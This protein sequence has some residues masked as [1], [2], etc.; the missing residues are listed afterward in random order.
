VT[1][2]WRW[3]VLGCLVLVPLAAAS[4]AAPNALLTLAIKCSATVM[5]YVAIRRYRPA[6]A[7]AW[8]LLWTA[9]LFVCLGDS[10][11]TGRLAFDLPAPGSKLWFE[12]P[13]LIGFPLAALGLFRL[14][15]RS[16]GHSAWE[17]LLDAVIV[18]AGVAIPVWSFVLDPAM[19]RGL[20]ADS[21]L[22][23][24]LTYP[25]IDLVIVIMI[26]RLWLNRGARTRSVGFLLIAQ[27]SML[28]AD[29]V[30]W[31]GS[32][33]Q[34]IPQYN[35]VASALYLIW[36]ISGVAA[37]MDPS[38]ARTDGSAEAA[39][40]RRG[41]T[42]RLLLLLMLS[43]VGPLSSV[44]AHRVADTEFTGPDL[45]VTPVLTALL[46]SALVLRVHLIARLSQRQ[47][48]L[49]TRQA[50][51]LNVALDEQRTLQHQLSHR[52]LHDP[53][54]GLGNRAMLH[55]RFDAALASTGTRPALLLLDLDGFKDVNDTYGHPV[56]DDLLVQVARRLLGAL[57]DSDTLVR[58]GGDEFAILLPD[59][60]ESGAFAVASTV[61]DAL[62][63]PYQH[64]ARDLYLTTSIGL[65]NVAGQ[66][67]TSEALR[68]ADL[69]LYA[70]KGAGKNQIVPF[71]ARLRTARLDHAQLVTGLRRALAEG[72]FT[73]HYQPVVDL[74]TG[75]TYAVEALLRW[76]PPGAESIPPDQF[77]AA[78]E[79]TGLILPIGAWVL[80]EACV[81]ASRWYASHGIVITVNVSGRQLRDTTF[82][83]TV[84]ET[85]RRHG[86]PGSALVLEITETVLVTAMAADVTT[87]VGQ[88]QALRALG[89][90][91]A[92]DDFGTGY[93]SLSYLRHL[94]VDVLKIDRSF[95]AGAESSAFTKAILQLSSS[96]HLQ[97]VAKG[98]ETD[99]Q[100]QL[101]REMNCEF[102]QGY[103]FSRPV[104][105]DG[106]D[107]L[108]G[109]GAPT[110]SD[111]V[112][113]QPVGH[114][115]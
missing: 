93:S 110:S 19:D 18:T 112:A 64:E 45:V 49:L 76:T 87:V 29:F 83:G 103:H 99:E 20:V 62:R 100:A 84:E 108:L 67:T 16:S 111:R 94:P 61:L 30:Y 47:A 55:E 63:V 75:R 89:I 32:P 74:D 15:G 96:L 11:F 71:E 38:M 70:A 9:L 113:A 66:A 78:A 5:A 73:L 50:G 88:L 90:R 14:I 21:G 60:T 53:L 102:A 40:R 17:S 37:V 31:W 72:E 57:S 23:A 101:L 81:H 39:T 91:V 107:S 54:T 114:Q 106:I 48:D 85:L 33:G 95:T 22:A 69:A 2:A 104:A 12:L 58:L 68:D 109:S 86:L 4:P 26:C 51:E 24:R 59:S 42:G 97:A 44:L 6:R 43:L 7:D 115:P 1:A 25:I 65:L 82:A 46:A 80:D 34:D 52:A 105:A 27:T 77:I 8:W 92:I 13:Y 3:Y 41:G 35:P 56:G 36:F 98:V 10:L 28:V 79:E